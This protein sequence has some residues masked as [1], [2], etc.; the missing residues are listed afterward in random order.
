M[1]P[2]P[3]GAFAFIT[4]AE[5][6]VL[7]G[8]RRDMDLWNLPGGHVEA[9]ESPWD[10]VVREVREEH[11]CEV[12]VDRLVQ[13]SFKT[14]TGEIVFQFACRVIGGEVGLSDEADEVRYFSRTELP[15]NLG[16]NARERIQKWDPQ[17]QGCSLLVQ[18][19][20]NPASDFAAVAEVGAT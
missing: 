12:E 1:I 10:A 11:G 19:A 13:L 16:P 20:S 9:G 3:M 14:R 5:G 8:H 6:G 4:N 15:A 18:A 17:D 7:L 2:R